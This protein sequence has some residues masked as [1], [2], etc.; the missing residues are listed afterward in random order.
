MP[1]TYAIIQ[2]NKY[3]D[4]TAYSG[5]G[6]NST[7][8]N[9]GVFKPDLVW[10]KSRTDT[11][12]HVLQDSVRGFTGATKLSSNST[13]AEN[14]NAGDATD[15]IYGWVT[16]ATSSGFSVY[17]G[18]TPSQ[19]NKSGQNYVGWQWQA[20]QGANVTNTTGTVTS[21]VSANTTAGFSIVTYTGTG[22]TGT[23]GHGLSSAPSMIILKSRNPADSWLVYHA[24]NPNPATNT[25]ILNDTIAVQTSSLNWN[26]TAPT[27]SVFSVYNP[28]S[29]G[30][31]NGNGYLYVAYC[32][33]AVPGFS[34]FG[35][36]TGNGAAD[37]PFIYLGFRPKFVLFKGSTTAGGW[38]I[39]DTAR[40]PYNISA[41]ALFPNAGN[42]EYT[43]ASDVGIDF[44]SNGIKI[45]SQGGELNYVSGQTYIYAAFAETPF[46]YANAR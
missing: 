6:G 46:K 31:S 27:S 34:A 8:T 43:I 45:R 30:Y 33:S 38:M 12:S 26:S 22:T 4:A 15:P 40:S 28:G 16:N 23:V 32:W 3:M 29:G 10:V 39:A 2:G 25:L 41:A 9:A 13:N 17:A 35:S 14:N 37:G 18:T 1:T 36:Y 24:G 20:A 7:V 42:V 19:V 44:L 5:A 21:K 11:G